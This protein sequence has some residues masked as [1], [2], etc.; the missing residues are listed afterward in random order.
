MEKINI[1][2]QFKADLES[3]GCSNGDFVTVYKREDGKVYFKAG[4][5]KLHLLKD[6]FENIIQKETVESYD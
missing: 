5:C 2:A 6:E 1:T 4:C 3:L